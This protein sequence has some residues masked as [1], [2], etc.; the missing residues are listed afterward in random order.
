MSVVSDTLIANMALDNVGAKSVI[1][2]LNENS[3]EAKACKLWY[4]MSRKQALEAY[5]WSFARRRLT[6]ASHSDAAPE[7]R[8]NFRYQYPADCLKARMIEN[9]LGH[10]ADAIPFEIELSDDASVK[11]IVTNEDD[12]VLIYTGDI[13]QTSLFSM[14]FVDTLASLLAARIAIKL[15]GKRTLKGDMIQQ[16]NALLRMAPAHDANEAVGKKPREAEHIRARG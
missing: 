7:L 2:S 5:D 11:T 15:T 4:D 1:A 10:E 6:L 3:P 8:W 14:F 16:Y 9:P 13:S 12:A